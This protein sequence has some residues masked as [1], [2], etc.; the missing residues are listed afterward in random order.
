MNGDLL[1]I[2]ASGAKA[3]RTALDATAQNIANASTDG[4]VRRSVGLAD[5]TSTSVGSGSLNATLSGVRVTGIVRNA[6]AARAAEVRRTG[7]DAARASTEVGAYS[8]VESAVEQTGVYSAI[9]SF[10]ADLQ[11]LAT[12][13]TDTAQRSVVLQDTQN[14]AQSFNAA[15]SQL[16]SVGTGLLQDAQT[17]AAQVNTIAGQLGQLNQQLVR[18]AATGSDQSGLLDQRDQLLGQLSGLTDITT[19]FA[20][21]GSVSVQLGGAGGPAVVSGASPTPF[22]ITAAANNTI[23]FAVG[24]TPVALTGGSLTGDQLGLSKV[25]ATGSALDAVAASIIG[26][27]NAAQANGADLNGAGGAAMFSGSG[28][29]SIAAVLQTPD[30]IATAPA[31]S[32]AGSRSTANIDA[33]NQAMTSANPAGAMDTLLSSISNTVAG[34]QT[35]SDALKSVADAATAAFQQGA[36]VNLDQEAVNL[37]KFQQAFQASGK[38]MQVATTLFNTLMAIQ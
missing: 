26:T 33:L 31:G 12:N 29:G 19:T 14:L 15:S 3:A 20:S 28:A 35:S 5:V 34:A 24:G 4:Y 38:V 10:Q 13:P 6:D 8:D 17:G 25:N 22:S 21:D 11:Q 9:G 16:T 7:S 32:A 1:A 23:T 2:A 27:A 36:G 37:V 30:Q 18:T